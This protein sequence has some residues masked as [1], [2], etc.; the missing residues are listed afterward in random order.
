MD[1]QQAQNIIK[2]TFER[3]F[4]KGLFAGFIKNLLNSFDETKA[5]HA[6][7]QLEGVIPG[8][9]VNA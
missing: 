4:D 2:E 1:K 5:F 9:C 3:P 8:E 6:R 7:V